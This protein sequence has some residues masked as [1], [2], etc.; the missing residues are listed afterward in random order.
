MT[1]AAFAFLSESHATII[2][3]RLQK[4]GDLA[5]SQ[6]PTKHLKHERMLVR[7]L[8]RPIVMLA[9]SPI[10]AGLS[11]YLALIYGYLYLLFT[12]F[13]T[14]FPQQYRFRTQTLGLSFLGMGVGQVLSLLVLSW[15]SDSLHDRLTKKHGEAKPE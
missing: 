6:I 1:I 11:L 3:S 5:L 4:K 7:S 12:T 13:S 2:R 14:V 10:V 9:K 8:V 15:L